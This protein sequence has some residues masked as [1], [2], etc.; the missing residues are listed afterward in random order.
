[1]SKGA[2]Q[3]ECRD[4]AR[5]FMQNTFLLSVEIAHGRHCHPYFLRGNTCHLD[6]VKGRPPWDSAA[7]AERVAHLRDCAP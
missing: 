1:M 7:H 4:S 2:E 6:K 5:C 3:A